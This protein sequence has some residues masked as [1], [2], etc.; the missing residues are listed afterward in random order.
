MVRNTV[1]NIDVERDLS[2]PIEPDNSQPPA[3][4]LVSLRR[5]RL[6]HPIVIVAWISGVLIAINAPNYAA[7]ALIPITLFLLVSKQPLLSGAILTSALF[8]IF[9][10]VGNFLYLGVTAIDVHTI[11][12]AMIFHLFFTLGVYLGGLAVPRSV[13][14]P[15]PILQQLWAI[16]MLA[17]IFLLIARFALNGTPLLNASGNRLEG[18]S[19]L[20]PYLGLISGV[21]PIITAYLPSYRGGLTTVLKFIVAFLVFLTGSRLLLAAVLVGYVYQYLR[22]RSDRK[23]TRSGRLVLLSLVGLAL[24]ITAIVNIYSIRTT[25]NVTLTWQERV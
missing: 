18:I 19:Q 6:A 1:V 20:N 14:Q 24:L 17:T 7:L 13:S 5:S 21:L 12:T 23:M 11:S 15:R 16:L 9:G 4:L 22:G 3:N 25:Q 8:T 2:S 10:A